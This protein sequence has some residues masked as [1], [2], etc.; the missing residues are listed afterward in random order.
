[1]LKHDRL[2]D[3]DRVVLPHLGAAY[4]LARWLLRDA[5]DAEDVLQDAIVRAFRFFDRFGGENPR[6]WL[7]KVVRNS[8]YTFLRRNR[9]REL[10]AEFDEELHGDPATTGRTFETPEESLQRSDRRH[11]LT[12]AVEGLPVEFREVFVLREIEGLSYKEI[13]EMAEIPI[14]TVMSRL[15]RAR[16]HLQTA[17]GPLKRAV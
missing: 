3:F 16:R 7:L 13:A 17:I 6:G 10:D 14:G 1:M 9:E 15:S 8:A 2:P 4:N 11:L 12:E 5:H